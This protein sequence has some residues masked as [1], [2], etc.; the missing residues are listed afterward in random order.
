[1]HP[2]ASCGS[3]GDGWIGARRAKRRQPRRRKNALVQAPSLEIANL[4]CPYRWTTRYQDNFIGCRKLHD[5]AGRQQWSGGFLS[6]YHQMAQPRT[7]TMP[8]IVLH[9]AQLGGDAKRIGD[10]LCRALVVGREAH[11]HMTIIENGIVLPIGFLDLI[12]GL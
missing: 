2:G 7:E 9:R 12:E 10:A 4:L 8:G 11:A 6:R 5:L 1:M 3:V